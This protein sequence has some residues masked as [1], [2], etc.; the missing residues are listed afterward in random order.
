M[1]RFVEGVDRE[2][3]TLFPKQLED[4]VAEDNPTRVVEALSRRLILAGWGSAV[5][6]RRRRAV[7]PITRRFL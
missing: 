3:S 6:I 4:F 2:Q 5:L 7:H 1:K